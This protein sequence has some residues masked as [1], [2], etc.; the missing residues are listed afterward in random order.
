MPDRISGSGTAQRS[1]PGAVISLAALFAAAGCGIDGE[2]HVATSEPAPPGT[3]EL[4]VS[5][6][7]GAVPEVE[8]EPSATYS[9]RLLL[10]AGY[11]DEKAAS[12]MGWAFSS[13]EGQTWT[14]CSADNPANC[15]G[16]PINF[17]ANQ[18]VT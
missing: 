3:A 17:A 1:L 9:A 16:G 14:K 18:D 11:N 5:G 4:I 10:V 7:G 15:N 6:S 2:P 8:Q 13:N 12:T